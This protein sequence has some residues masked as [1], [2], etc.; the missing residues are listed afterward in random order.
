MTD[1]GE[2]HSFLG[3]S[4]KRNRVSHKIKLSQHAYVLQVLKKFNMEPCKPCATP[5]STSSQLSALKEP[6]SAKDIA[7]MAE[8]P[9]RAACGSLQHLQVST[10]PDVSKAVSHVCQFFHNYGEEHWSVVKRVMRYLKGTAKHGLLYRG[11][12]KED[13]PRLELTAYCDSNWAGDREQRKST[14]A[15]VLLAAGTGVSWSSKKLQTICLSSAEAE[16]AACREAAKEIV[17]QSR[18]AEGMNFGY[19]EPTRLCSDSQSAIAL[20]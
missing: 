10:R 20:T 1:L 3:I 7:R 6:L 13:I 15:Y 18:F 12:G 17:C 2:L 9:Y 19:S 16:Y 14:A 8:I 5:A 4:V 11:D